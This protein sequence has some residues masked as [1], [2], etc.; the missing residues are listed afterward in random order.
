MVNVDEGARLGERLQ[1]N[2]A[3]LHELLLRQDSFGRAFVPPHVSTDINEARRTIA[4]LKASLYQLGCP[5]ADQPED[6]DPTAP[7]TPRDD[8]NPGVEIFAQ[9][10]RFQHFL[11]TPRL[12]VLLKTLE[13]TPCYHIIEAPMGYGK[14]ALVGE[15]WRR[16]G[17]GKQLRLAYLFSRDHGRSRVSQAVR[18]LYRQLRAQAVQ[19]TALPEEDTALTS[20]ALYSVARHG[21][22][23]LIILDGLDEC[24]DAERPLLGH[25]LPDSLVPKVAIVVTLRPTVRQL[26]LPYLAH[27]HVLQDLELPTPGQGALLHR[28]ELLSEAELHTLL[29]AA[30][31]GDAPALARRIFDQSRGLP[32][33]AVPYLEHPQLLDDA[34]SGA[35]P[36]DAYY[37]R[38]LR[39]IKAQCPAAQHELL[40][41]LLALLAAAR[42]PLAE[43]DLAE[44]LATPQATIST[45][46][47]LLARYQHL[48]E[49]GVLALDRHFRAH[50]AHADETRAAVS[51]AAAQLTAWTIRFTGAARLS[52]V[53]LYALRHAAEYLALGPGLRDL[54][55]RPAWFS[56]LER[57]CHSRSACIKALERTQAE[58]DLHFTGAADDP[59][60]VKMLLCALV[61]AS[62]S[63]TLLPELVAQLVRLGLWSEVEALD[64]AENYTSQA[65]RQALHDLLAHPAQPLN[66]P[67]GSAVA[68]AAQIL[69]RYVTLLPAARQVALA[70]WRRTYEQAGGDTGTLGDRDRLALLIAALRQSALSGD[71]R[72]T[73]A[74][75]DALLN[76]LYAYHPPLTGPM[77]DPQ[78]AELLGA[79]AD[80]WW[81]LHPRDAHRFWLQPI[82]ATLARFARADLIEALEL[83]AP[84]LRTLFPACMDEL[85]GALQQIGQ[86]LL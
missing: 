78:F 47:S 31:H 76:E 19:K 58:L 60:V 85:C 12:T 18:S 81:Q 59:T 36:V 6:T 50:L 83:L 26:V 68:E 80:T 40:A 62:L 46:R 73:W 23:M 38:A 69:R 64:Y 42:S 34:R 79:L 63:A 65:N 2:R 21:T 32:M 33:V 24:D 30:G 9:H 41:R 11:R 55:A 66:F 35:I 70:G 67:V 1:I 39:L 8:L 52:E 56:E 43:A 20:S 51:E 71:E 4:A 49:A 53:P 72:A 25:L 27:N 54:L 61:R 13:T 15:L 75:F 3:R 22:P 37:E 77:S 17:D 14:T 45:L 29:L 16:F 48:D 57:R 7:L 10:P 44:L 82:L 84:T 5:A 28:L 86:A 74:N